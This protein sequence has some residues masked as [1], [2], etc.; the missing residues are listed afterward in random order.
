MRSFGQVLLRAR[1][2]AAALAV[3]GAISVGVPATAQDGSREERPKDEIRMGLL[4]RARPIEPSYDPNA[5]PEDDAIAG[6]RLALRD[7]NGTGAFT[8]Q[9]YALE[10]AIL[11]EGRSA[12]EAAREL[13]A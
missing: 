1:R 13:V 12:P 4:T 7:N 3:L 2:K 11:E 6:A 5:A 10:E 8:G 9:R